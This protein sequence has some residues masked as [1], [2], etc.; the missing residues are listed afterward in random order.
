MAPVPVR[1][2]EAENLIKGN[3]ITP[4]LIEKAVEIS[5]KDCHLLRKNKAKYIQ[6]KTYVKRFLESI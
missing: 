2:S 3:V 4:E 6:A 5:F 1:L